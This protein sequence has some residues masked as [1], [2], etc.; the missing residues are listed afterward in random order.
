MIFSH[1]D[2]LFPVVLPGSLVDNFSHGNYVY[3]APAK[4]SQIF[5]GSPLQGKEV[6]R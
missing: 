1:K 6:G 5:C 3:P 4:E 2:R